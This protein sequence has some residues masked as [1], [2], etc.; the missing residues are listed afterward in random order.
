MTQFS[1]EYQ[2]ERRGDPHK[3]AEANNERRMMTQA[4]IMA[5]KRE[6]K[7]AGGKPTKRLNVIAEKLAQ[8]AEEG[9]T[10]SIKE[11]FDRVD[12]KAVQAIEHDLSE[13]AKAVFLWGGKSE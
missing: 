12:G 10:A 3:A 13:E 11:V 4:L 5:L 7:D 8:K 1:S 6:A 2:P 9:D